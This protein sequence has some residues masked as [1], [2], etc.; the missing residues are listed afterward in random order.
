MEVRNLT[1]DEIAFVQVKSAS[2]QA[3]LGFRYIEQFEVAEW[4][5]YAPMIFAVHYLRP[6][7][8]SR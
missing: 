2:D 3:E 1:A 6:L 5:R 8:S 7:H 4:D